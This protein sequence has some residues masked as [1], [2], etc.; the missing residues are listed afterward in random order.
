MYFRHAL[1]PTHQSL[2]SKA[3]RFLDLST[4]RCEH[5]HTRESHT[6][7]CGVPK[8]VFTTLAKILSR[9]R[10]RSSPKSSSIARNARSIL[11]KM[12]PARSLPAAEAKL[13]QSQFHA[14]AVHFL[15][16]FFSRHCFTPL[17]CLMMRWNG[18]DLCI[19]QPPDP[20]TWLAQRVE[21][22]AAR[23]I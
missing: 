15:E 16:V 3:L 11:P 17:P 13:H 7:R 1:S 4:L 6:R 19:E 5:R 14:M 18:K 9:L 20:V 10:C 23:R 12:P 21:V 22:N 8:K 2:K